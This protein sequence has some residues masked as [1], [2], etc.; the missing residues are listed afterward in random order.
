MSSW[1]WQWWR[2]REWRKLENCYQ[3][4]CRAWDIS[5][6]ANWSI[7]PI[8][9]HII[10]NWANIECRKKIQLRSSHHYSPAET[11]LVRQVWKISTFSE[12]N[13]LRWILIGTALANNFCT[14]SC[15]SAI[16]LYVSP[17][18]TICL[19][20]FTRKQHRRGASEP[21]GDF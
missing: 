6:I 8:E 15:I 21:I 3:E 4:G 10:N 12:G 11:G 2:Y 18:Y 16:Y 5:K 17:L 1:R 9:M 20:I 14:L 19:R 7:I 13:C